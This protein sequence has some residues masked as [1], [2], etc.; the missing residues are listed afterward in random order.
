MTA[1]DLTARLR[2]HA[3]ACQPTAQSGRVLLE[4][5]VEHLTIRENLHPNV[6]YDEELLFR[7]LCTTVEQPELTALSLN[8][9]DRALERPPRSRNDQQRRRRLRGRLHAVLRAEG[10]IPPAAEVRDYARTIEA[11]RSAPPAGRRSLEWWL[12]RRSHDLGAHEL[13]REARHHALLEHVLAENPDVDDDAAIQL[14]MK[15]LVLRVVVCRC[16]P[17]TR[18]DDP[19]RCNSCGA[20]PDTS[21]TRPSPSPRCQDKYER[22]A[23]RYLRESRRLSHTATTSRP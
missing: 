19:L 5:Y 12:E 18:R 17:V 7:L 16:P 20:T 22:T 15:R 1:D 4:L 11:V 8:A 10:V 14:W 21:G 3:G 13:A 23:R 6:Y 9:I 2:A